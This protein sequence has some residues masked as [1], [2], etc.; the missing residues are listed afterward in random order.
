MAALSRPAASSTTATGLPP[1]GA[2]P[3]TSTWTNGRPIASACLTAPVGRRSDREAGDP[4]GLE[5][6]VEVGGAVQAQPLEGPG[7]QAGGVALVAHHH[8]G[9]LVPGVVDLS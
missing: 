2:A 7:G 4:P 6:A 8:H 1:K 9:S 3:N 5:A